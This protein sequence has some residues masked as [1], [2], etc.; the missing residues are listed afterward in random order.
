MFSFRIDDDLELRLHEEHHA[1]EMYAL[2]DKN[3]AHIGRWL[4]FVDYTD[5]VSDTLEFIRGARK[6]WAE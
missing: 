1:E 5:A 3:R 6:R 4:P 2:V